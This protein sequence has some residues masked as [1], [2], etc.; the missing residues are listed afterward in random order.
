M[1]DTNKSSIEDNYTEFQIQARGIPVDIIYKAVQGRMP[2]MPSLV[3][4]DVVVGQV[5]EC[6]EKYG[7]L[8]TMT[9]GRVIEK[10]V[11][12]A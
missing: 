5:Q 12:E 3:C 7:I 2:S 6:I 11:E 1:T 9:I 8:R 4:M 10:I